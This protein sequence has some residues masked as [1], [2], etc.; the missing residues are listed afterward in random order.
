MWLAL[1]MTVLVAM[2]N[3]TIDFVES[4][5][6]A[7]GPMGPLSG[8]MLMPETPSSPMVLIVPGS[9]PTDRDG[10]GPLGLNA[11]TYKLLAEGLAARG[12]ATVRID[13]RGM[14][15][16]AGAVSDPNDVTAQDYATD[17]SSWIAAIREHQ[18]GTECV[19]VL[20]HSEGGLMALLA[21][22][23]PDIET[24]GLVL[25]ASTGRPLGE[26]LRDQ[27]K[28]QLAGTPLLEPALA[29]ITALEAGQHV[30]A[31]D[32]DPKLQPVF[33]PQVQDFL[34]STFTLDP[35]EMIAAY[36]KPVLIV[37]G[38]R[39][40]QVSVEDARRLAAAAP[41]SE[42]VLLPHANHVLKDVRSSDRAANIA[43]YGDSELPLAP[44][45][46]DAIAD[47]VFSTSAQD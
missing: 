41:E 8:T 14:F 21:G 26:I 1:T 6:T 34:I 47:F 20:G 30:D 3:P 28:P 45:A 40:L 7:P 2:G 5:V 37:Q 10:N 31:S 15:G 36:T 25:V 39:D 4:Q 33:S 12:I 13:K 11:S 23:D 24:C 17:I 44:G 38:E 46:V 27:L 43:T 18:T 9:G 29:T 35:A 42:L 22:Q 16:S 19:W 32:I